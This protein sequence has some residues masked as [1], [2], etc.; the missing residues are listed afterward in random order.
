MRCAR[1]KQQKQSVTNFVWFRN[2]QRFERMYLLIVMIFNVHT[3]IAGCYLTKSL[4][5]VRSLS[6]SSSAL[7]YSHEITNAIKLW[8]VVQ[9][10][11]GFKWMVISVN[12]P[13]ESQRCM[14]NKISIIDPSW[15]KIKCLHIILPRFELP[16]LTFNLKM[17]L[18]WLRL[19]AFLQSLYC[20]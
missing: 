7:S 18:F 19:L 15:F 1:F 13:S 12:A 8:F 3:A 14:R 20:F 11:C 6:I 10:F 9:L 4:Y 2:V 16:Q 17:L 5:L